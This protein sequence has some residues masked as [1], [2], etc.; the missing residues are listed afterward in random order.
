MS[1]W[2]LPDLRSE[3]QTK[4]VFYFTSNFLIGWIKHIGNYTQKTWMYE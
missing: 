1:S 2:N 4:F 3:Q